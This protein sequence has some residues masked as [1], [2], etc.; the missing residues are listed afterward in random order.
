MVTRNYAH[1]ALL[2]QI[3]KVHNSTLK[4]SHWFRFVPP[5]TM[6]TRK[7][8]SYH[9]EKWCK[10]TPQNAT[11]LPFLAV[12]LNHFKSNCL[13]HQSTLHICHLGHET[14]DLFCCLV[15]MVTNHVSNLLYI[16]LQIHV[17]CCYGDCLFEL[18]FISYS[19]VR[20]TFYNCLILQTNSCF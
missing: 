12:K 16:S 4:I 2:S 5:I 9:A 1:L 13:S 3:S 11:F 6:A 20:S 17:S 18:W 15:A 7:M 19:L 8:Q 10:F 14:F